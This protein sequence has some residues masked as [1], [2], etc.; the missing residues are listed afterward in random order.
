MVHHSLVT[1]VYD[2]VGE[3]RSDE[4]EDEE[5]SKWVGWEWVTRGRYKREFE[6]D[7]GLLTVASDE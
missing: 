3:D 4:R 2:E 1:I 5:R 7:C 6:I